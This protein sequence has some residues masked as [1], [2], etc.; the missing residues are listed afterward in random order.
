ML[1]ICLTWTSCCKSLASRAF[2][3][4]VALS[5]TVLQIGPSCHQGLTVAFVNIV[6][7]GVLFPWPFCTTQWAMIPLCNNPCRDIDL[8]LV[9]ATISLS[10]GQ[11][12]I[13][14]RNSAYHGVGSSPSSELFPLEEPS[15]QVVSIATS[16]APTLLISFII[17]II[18]TQYPHPCWNL[19]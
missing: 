13:P 16:L 19:R 8:S 18:R 12:I 9:V 15:P 3:Q 7:A 10:H 11:T 4:F 6:A 2:L 1:F 14:S 17:S 5:Q